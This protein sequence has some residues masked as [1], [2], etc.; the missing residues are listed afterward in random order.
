[1]MS[2]PIV[3]LLPLL[4]VLGASIPCG[5]QPDPAISPEAG[6]PGFESVAP[7]DGWQTGT[8]TPD[9]IRYFADTSA[10]KG[11]RIR[12]AHSLFPRTLAT[13]G[14]SSASSFTR[15]INSLVYE[16][17]IALNPLTMEVISVLASHWKVGADGQTYFFRIDPNARFSDG[18]PVTT[19]DVLATYKLA[20]DSTILSPYT[21][22]LYAEFD[23]PQALSKYIFSVRSKTKNWKNMLYFGGTTILP[24]H[25][26]GGL[27]GREYIERY[28]YD[29]VPGSGPYL[30]PEGGVVHDS[31]I[32]LTR[33]ANW[34]AKDYPIHRGLYNFDSI[35]I[36]FI[37]NAGMMADLL[38]QGKIDYMDVHV[39]LFWNALKEMPVTRRG[40][41]QM[42]RIETDD[43]PGISG[44]VFNMRKPPFDD[45][46]I[47]EAF[48][49]IFAPERDNVMRGGE[50]PLINSYFPNSIYEN[51]A[52]RRFPYDSMAIVKLLAD[53]GYTRSHGKLSRR[54]R[55]L[56][57]EAL[58]TEEGAAML[59]RFLERARG[60]GIGM[61]VRLVADND[62]MLTA[63]RHDFTMAM[64]GWGGRMSIPNP[65]SSFHSSL[66][67]PT[68]TNNM[69]GLK[70]RIA[71][72]LMELE[73][74]TFDQ[75]ER[76]RILRTLDSILIDER[77]S[78]L[79]WYSP[80]IHVAYLNKFGHPEFYLGRLADWTGVLYTWWT[81]PKKE[82][83]VA[84]EFRG[85]E[86]RME[87]E[88]LTVHFW[89]S[90][91]KAHPIDPTIRE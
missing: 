19:E 42:K 70:S 59:S 45:A 88:P 62:L 12:I 28:R 67:D 64:V 4:L 60:F 32:T 23:P 81:D 20:M 31:T 61:K 66:A 74:T 16:P 51:P 57:V 21:N 53:A 48:I 82:L 49:R 55:P 3:R 27:S 56:T 58:L 73:Q 75:K 1:M 43:P 87:V 71:D 35:T 78:A 39:P 83:K 33:R 79:A 37:E 46:R 8:L 90:Y 52:N 68:G 54:G 80:D 24:A 86:P 34:W 6:G 50:Y 25:V 72:S 29:Q 76:V 69:P 30:I 17:L 84:S 85:K 2:S 63:K 65:I 5:A 15:T 7:Q 89:R 10:R 40:V 13:F 14:E 36:S 22:S 38:L 91:D 77:M 9:Q 44:L 11:G 26:I 18:H 41:I 47:R